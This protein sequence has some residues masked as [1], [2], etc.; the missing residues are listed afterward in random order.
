MTPGSNNATNDFCFD[1][2]CEE[3]DGHKDKC[4]T[5]SRETKNMQPMATALE[6]FFSHDGGEYARAHLER[7]RRMAINA[8]V[9]FIDLWWVYSDGA[10]VL[11]EE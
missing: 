5:G 6:Q 1:S 10:W 4:T 11:D 8:N 3:E 2:L 7:A 9:V